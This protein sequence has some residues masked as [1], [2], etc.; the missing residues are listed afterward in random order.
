MEVLCRLNDLNVLGLSRGHSSKPPRRTARAILKDK[1]DRYAV[2]YSKKFDLYTLPGG[3]VELGEDLLTALNRELWE[4][5]GCCIE[6]F[7]ELGIVE[8]N[9]ACQDYT[10][11]S[12]YFLVTTSHP[13]AQ[14]QLTEDEARNATEVQ[15]HSFETLVSLIRCKTY[16]TVQQKY[17]QARD[18]AALQAYMKKKRP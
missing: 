12:Y 18:L 8:E 6:Q 11:E 2:M 10:Q 3:G 14:P 13:T 4:E 7:E 1:N 16:A 17:L 5:T 9:R 15:W